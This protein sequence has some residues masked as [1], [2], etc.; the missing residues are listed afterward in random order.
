[1]IGPEMQAGRALVVGFGNELRGDD[2][3]G[4]VV[5]RA[6]WTRRHR[7]PALAGA[8]FIWSAQLVPEMALD[9]SGASFAVFVDAA[10][11]GNAPGSVRLSRLNGAV[12]A[13]ADSLGEVVGALGCWADL[14]P[15]GL[16]CLSAEL[17]G[18]APPAALVT[19]SVDVPGV[20][21]CLSP[22]VRRAVPAAVGA[23]E[24]AIAAWRDTG[25]RGT[26]ISRGLLHA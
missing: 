5:A 24:G 12:T 7:A 4:Q 2:G 8:S 20:G 17:F 6:L 23:V 13:Q 22:V 10:Y 3:V 9:L 14:S 26:P 18:A 25:A 11:D 15:T 21:A 1:L 16:L 19:V